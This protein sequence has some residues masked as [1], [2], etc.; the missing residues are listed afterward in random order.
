V[1]VAD[2]ILVRVSPDEGDPFPVGRTGWGAAGPRR[3]RNL[4]DRRARVR[5]TT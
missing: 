1:S 5:R 2:K 4:E 3:V